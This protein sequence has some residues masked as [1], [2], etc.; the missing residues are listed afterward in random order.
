MDRKTP[1]HFNFIYI[2]R[3]F[4]HSAQHCDF[5]QPN[6]ESVANSFRLY[7]K[8]DASSN[9]TIDNM[10]VFNWSSG[11][12]RVVV[13]LTYIAGR[14]LGSWQSLNSLL[15]LC[16]WR[17]RPK[18]RERESLDE[19]RLSN[20]FAVMQKKKML[21]TSRRRLAV[22]R[23]RKCR[24]AEH[25]PSDSG[26]NKFNFLFRSTHLRALLIIHPY[27][28]NIKVSR[29]K[30]I[31]Q[32]CLMLLVLCHLHR[33]CDSRMISLTVHDLEKLDTFLKSVVS[34]NRDHFML[35]VMCRYNKARF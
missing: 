28:V 2:F 9:N 14:L 34:S 16:N 20:V 19:R 30:M 21:W 15:R 5:S 32:K 13:W 22:I 35:N 10:I 1:P 3:S 8:K 4:F 26:A 27:C 31:I 23:S 12:F 25:S 33:L 29:D 7:E 6:Y 17:K 24:K 11:I 18:K